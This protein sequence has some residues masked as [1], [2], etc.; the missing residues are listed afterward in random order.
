MQVTLIWCFAVFQAAQCLEGV[1]L[2]S[3]KGE[4]EKLQSSVGCED[5]EQMNQICTPIQVIFIFAILKTP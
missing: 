5:S 4:C 3:V 1:V 2:S